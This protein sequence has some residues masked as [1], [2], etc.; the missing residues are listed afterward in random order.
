MYKTDVATHDEL[1][2]WNQIISHCPY[3]EALHTVEWRNALTTCFQQLEPLYFIIRNVGEPRKR[4]SEGASARSLVPSLPCSLPH[5]DDSGTVVGAFPCFVFR[6]MPLSKMLL[7]MPWTLPGGPL[8]LP[9]A[10]VVEA[11]LSVIQK[12]D[13]ISHG[14]GRFETF[15]YFET[16]LTLPRHCSHD[17]SNS[18]VSAGYLR[19]STNFTHILETKKGYDEIWKAYNKR[20]RGAVRKARKVGV[21]VRETEGE[22]EMMDF[23]KLYLALV[24]H[25][26]SK[27]A[28]SSLYVTPKPYGLLR[29]LQTS[30]I[31]RLVVAELDST[32]TDARA[33]GG[34]IIAGLLFLHFNSSVRL[35]CE[36]SDPNFLSYRPNNAVI[37]YIIRWACEHGYPRVDF[38]ASPP[39]SKGLIAFKE[40][41][42]A[43]KAWFYTFTKLHSSWKKKLWVVS[44]PALRRVYAAIQRFRVRSV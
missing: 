11:S 4:G 20:V 33:P 39:E 8:I 15:P 13:E 3:S 17:I 23:Y 29:Y 5:S 28:G 42:R 7:S 35:W 22:A 32:A 44:E 16:T 19:K 6:P 1:K 24:E 25:F 18:L 9:G 34:R 43:Q 21:I 12:L 2:Y 37:D 31:A 36:A 38:G 30:P 14:T 26:N 27:R 40:E 41:W 10:N